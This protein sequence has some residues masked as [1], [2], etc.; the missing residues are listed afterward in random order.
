MLA[1]FQ[2]WLQLENNMLIIVRNINNMLIHT[3]MLAAGQLMLKQD[4]N[5]VIHARTC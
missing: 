1:N 3:S 2:L 4:N 5:I